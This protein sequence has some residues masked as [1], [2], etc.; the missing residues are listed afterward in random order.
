[1][2]P[3][4]I[5]ASA[6][7]DRLEELENLEREKVSEN[8]NIMQGTLGISMQHVNFRYAKGD[9]YILEDFTH[10]FRPGSKTALTGRTGAGK[11]TIFRL[12]L[13]LTQPESGSIN[14]YNDKEQKT[15]CPDTRCNMVFVPQG[16]TLMS[17][18]IKYNLKLAK[19]DATDDEL[20][21]VL[22]MAVADFV[23]DLPQGMDTECG[24]RGAGL[25]EGQAQRIAIARGLLRPG[26]ILLLD[27]ISSSLD[28]QTERT[29]FTHLFEN[30]PDKTMI[31]ISHRP[32]ISQ[33]CDEIIEK[34]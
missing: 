20:R 22:H 1:M 25:S 7:I 19:P 33:L 26:S 34:T 29:L 17:G 14:I 31:M 15:I 5:H 2:V 9:H 13:A 30:Y 32:S 8:K 6:S 4:L 11:T 10:D 12:L 3:Q 27:E 18:T 23:L 28:E 24:E 16:N 21:H